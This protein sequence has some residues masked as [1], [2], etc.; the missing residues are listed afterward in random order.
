[1]ETHCGVSYLNMRP[2]ERGFLVLKFRYINLSCSDL[3][4]IF[5][6]VGTAQLQSWYHSICFS[7]CFTKHFLIWG[8]IAV[9][10]EYLWHLGKG[11]ARYL[12]IKKHKYQI[13]VRLLQLDH[14]IREHFKS[15]H[16]KLW[17]ICTL[18]NMCCCNIL[19]ISCAYYFWQSM[20]L[21]KT[22]E[23]C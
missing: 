23:R 17:P 14:E 6:D 3:M 13:R 8:D 10:V 19:Y 20:C 16:H 18:R 9:P 2:D 1:M 7:I 4:S 15:W 22:W 11:L 21:S 12:K 5:S